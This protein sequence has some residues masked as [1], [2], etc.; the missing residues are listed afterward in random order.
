[1][2]KTLKN[3][4][5]KNRQADFHETWYVS[6]GTSAH[7]SLFKLGPWSD[8]DLFYGKVKFGNIGFSIGKSDGSMVVDF[9][10]AIAASNM[11][12]S[13]SRHLIEYMK[14]YEY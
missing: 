9:S 12:V 10:K 5:L 3:L 6:L 1:M 4:L 13:K 2:V 14:I 8:L 7:C 11:K